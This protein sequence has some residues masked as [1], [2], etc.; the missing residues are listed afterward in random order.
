MVDEKV[1]HYKIDDERLDIRGKP[2]GEHN[3][4]Y[5]M[6]HPAGFAKATRMIGSADNKDVIPLDETGHIQKIL[7]VDEVDSI[8]RIK[9]V[10][11]RKDSPIV[12]MWGCENCIY[13]GTRRCPYGIKKKE[14]HSNGYCTMAIKENLIMAKLMRSSNGMRHI[15]NMNIV[16]DTKLLNFY[17]NKLD[18]MKEEDKLDDEEVTLLNNIIKMTENLG[19]RMDKAI[20][21]EDGKVVKIENTFTPNDFN[22][23]MAKANE[24]VVDAEIVKEAKTTKEG[25]DDTESEE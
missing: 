4:R 9:N 15:R 10:S 21:Q 23:L 3:Y 6:Q 20:E 1:G 11:L 24:K 19:K 7:G 5:T 14:T 18:D 22:R 8:E 25:A 2:R 13:R 17:R 12:H 16:Q